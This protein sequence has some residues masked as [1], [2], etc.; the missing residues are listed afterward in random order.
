MKDCDRYS[1][2]LKKIRNH[3]CTIIICLNPPVVHHLRGSLSI[4]LRNLFLMSPKTSF[5]LTGPWCSVELSVGVKTVGAI[6]KALAP[7]GSGPTIASGFFLNKFHFMLDGYTNR[8]PDRT[9]TKI[10]WHGCDDMLMNH[11]I[12][13]WL[14]YIHRPPWKLN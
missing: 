12:L 7:V 11:F 4:S 8:N 2:S 10:R 6:V 13:C 9:K 3:V 14:C 5:L 1:C